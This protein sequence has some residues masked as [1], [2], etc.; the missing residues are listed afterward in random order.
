[1]NPPQFDDQQF[2]GKH[3]FIMY[4]ETVIAEMMHSYNG[5]HR[6]DVFEIIVPKWDVRL[7]FDLQL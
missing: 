3:R 6:L 5:N 2:F 7:R 1:V 4:L